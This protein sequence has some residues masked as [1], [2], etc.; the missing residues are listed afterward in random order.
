MKTENTDEL[1]DAEKAAFDKIIKKV[2]APQLLENRIIN[3]LKV[4]K[5]ITTY[6]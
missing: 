6:A 2:Q 1:S 3:A 5:L 4:E